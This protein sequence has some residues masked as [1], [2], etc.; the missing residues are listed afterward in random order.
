[1]KTAVIYK[2]ISGFT[3]QYAK[4]IA[5]ETRGDLF[6]YSKVTVNKLGEYDVLIFGGNLHATGISGTG[7]IKKNMNLFEGKK[8][9][10][11]AVGASPFRESILDELWNH[12]F[13]DVPKKRLSLFYLRGGF[14]FSRLNFPNKILMT[15]LK[16]MLQRK[17]KLSADE[18]G[19][20][21][22]FEHPVDFTAKEN[23]QPLLECVAGTV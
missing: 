1:M 13:P 10:V 7:F 18:Q 5:E 15:L 11:F 16:W 23:I 20:L 3:E 9:V 19:M 12:N 21:T 17:K 6:R 4:W 2:T 22:A 14:N 8:I